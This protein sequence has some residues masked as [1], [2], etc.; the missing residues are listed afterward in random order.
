MSELCLSF[1]PPF[2]LSLRSIDSLRFVRPYSL[3]LLPPAIFLF[4]RR[5]CANLVR[6][7]LENLERAGLNERMIEVHIKREGI[8][9]LIVLILSQFKMLLS[10]IIFSSI[11]R[12]SK[13]LTRSSLTCIMPPALS[14]SPQYLG[15]EN[16]VTNLRSAKNSNP[17]STTWRQKMN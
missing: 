1:L 16:T 12:K 11:K 2:I 8:L 7:W 13:W 9:I 3:L 15:A 4:V 6:N 17:S 10:S 14:N 5:I